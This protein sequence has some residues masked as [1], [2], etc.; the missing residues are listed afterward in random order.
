M[1]CL[2]KSVNES[3]IIQS[4]GGPIE[5]VVNNIKT[6]KVQI[7]FIAAPCKYHA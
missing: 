6:G 3:V 4:S 5:A 1:L 2:T 7:G